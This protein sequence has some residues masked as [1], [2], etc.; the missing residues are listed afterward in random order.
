MTLSKMVKRFPLFL[1]SLSLAGSLWAEAPVYDADTL[2]QQYD[3]P[4]QAQTPPANP[5][6]QEQKRR[7]LTKITNLIINR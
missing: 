7:M 3:D 2:Q 1:C 4:Q 6:Q 5:G